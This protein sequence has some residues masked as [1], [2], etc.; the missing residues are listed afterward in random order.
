MQSAAYWSIDLEIERDRSKQHR[1]L[2]NQNNDN[3]EIGIRFQT[4]NVGL[5]PL[6]LHH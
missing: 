1:T 4:L 3:D 2:R 5:N 6:N